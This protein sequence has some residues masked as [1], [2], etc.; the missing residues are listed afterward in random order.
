M[1]Q[2]ITNNGKDQNIVIGKQTNILVRLLK[3]RTP[4]IAAVLL[5]WSG[6]VAYSINIVIGVYSGLDLET[7]EQNLSN[8]RKKGDRVGESIALYDIG[9]FY[10]YE[11]EYPAVLKY[12]KQ[13]LRITREIGNKDRERRTLDQIGR[14]YKEH[15][16]YAAAL[17]YY[18]QSLAVI[19]ESGDQKEERNT[20]NTIGLLC[21]I[22]NKYPAAVTSYAQ[23]L[24]VSRKLGDEEEERRTLN[25]IGLIYHVRGE[26]AAALTYYGQNL[27][28]SRESRDKAGE[29]TACWNISRLYTDQGNSYKAKQYMS[30]AVQPTY[31]LLEEWLGHSLLEGYVDYSKLITFQSGES[32]ESLEQI[33]SNSRKDGDRDG[34]RS[35]LYDIGEVYT[36]QGE[37]TTALTYYKQSL[38][39]SREIGN[40]EWERRILDNIGRIY[41]EQGEY[42]A[43]LTY[44]KQNLPISREIGG[45]K[46]WGRG[47]EIGGKEWERRILDN[48]AWLYNI[49]DEYPA[50]LKYYEQSLAISRDK[51][52]KANER[53]T[54]NNI[55]LIC[56]AQGEYAA[57]LTYYE[58]NLHNDDQF[59]RQFD[60]FDQFGPPSWYSDKA[61]E[62]ITCWNISRLYT[63]QGKPD[64]AKP[65]TN[66]AVQL[67]YQLLEGQLGHPLM[68][69]YRKELERLRAKRRGR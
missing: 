11:N 22:L 69:G 30:W 2:T 17:T 60:P 15:G 48:I 13:S 35:T 68:E 3:L 21:E 45:S 36:R 56:H 46:N 10:Y 18:E 5:A 58:Q 25:N 62:A 66:R 16:E 57:A 59:F 44:C 26:Y 64:K 61:C 65:Y 31:Q 43:A 47:F 49:L 4:V 29:A 53:N 39:I 19:R 28:I 52:D 20:L 7:L 67:T 40:K 37:Y 38:R 23:S 34:V 8:S 42:T 51:G 27:R 32:L 63:D 12:Y 55:G 9:M 6:G 24:A 1:G 14:I 54:L 33:L 41:K 50:A